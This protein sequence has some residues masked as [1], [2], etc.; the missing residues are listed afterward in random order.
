MSDKPHYVVVARTQNVAILE[1]DIFP[2][3]TGAPVVVSNDFTVA[4]T[5]VGV[6]QITPKDP[7]ARCFVPKVGFSMTTPAPM[8][9]TW[10]GLANIT[11]NA[12]A[13][14]VLTLSVFNAA[15]AAVDLAA[16]ADNRIGIEIECQ[17]QKTLTL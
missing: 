6:Y 17:N 15:G 11:Q 12:P 7:Y 5:G 4:R 3:G 9:A 13:S 10:S 16:T 14:R 1:G 8:S 2:Q